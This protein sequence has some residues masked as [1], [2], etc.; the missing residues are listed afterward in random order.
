MFR[1]LI[2]AAVLISPTLVQARAHLFTRHHSA[3]RGG[4]YVG[5]HGS[6]HKGG[7]YVSRTGAHHYRHHKL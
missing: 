2:A 3:D 1:I 7:H 5:G 4:H 6:S